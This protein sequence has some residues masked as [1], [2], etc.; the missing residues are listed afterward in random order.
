M[1]NDGV[2]IFRR[3]FI[4]PESRTISVSLAREN[5]ARDSM[6]PTAPLR[7]NF[8]VFATTPYANPLLTD[9]W[10][11]DDVSV[12]PTGTVPDGGSTVSLLGCAL[13]GLAAVRRKLGC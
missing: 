8:G 10:F 3:V 7:N 9:I 5:D 1:R 4:D 11:V 6:K 2:G 12:T 13:L